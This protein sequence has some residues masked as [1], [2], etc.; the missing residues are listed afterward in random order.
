MSNDRN[1]KYAGNHPEEEE[2]HFSDEDVSYEVEPESENQKAAPTK[3]IKEN[4]LERVKGSKRILIGIAGFFVLV[5][6]VYKLFTPSTSAPPSEIVAQSTTAAP[7]KSMSATRA[8]AMTAPA[9]TNQVTTVTTTQQAPAS[10]PAQ[11]SAIAPGAP[12][13]PSAMNQ[14]GQ[15]G[16][17]GMPVVI[18]VQPPSPTYP[19]REISS[20]PGTGAELRMAALSA[21]NEKLMA[22]FQA[23]YI[24][25]LNEFAAQN[26][27]LQDQMQTL[28]GRVANMEAQMNQLMQTITQQGGLNSSRAAAPAGQVSPPAQQAEMKIPY[29]VQAIIPG[30]A[31]LRSENGETITV[32]EGDTIKDIGRVTK[33]DPYDGIVEINTGSKS[34]SLSYGNG[35]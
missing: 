14:P 35:G 21:E 29:N 22:Q 33:I 32:A 31:W 4:L 25:K 20:Q 30:R 23:N 3:G 5:L 12:V 11:P 15:N 8:P 26:K 24:Q 17:P 13:N 19:N 1:D 27:A 16:M 18:P 7:P 2:Y 9:A 28:N 34:I 10:A 6:V